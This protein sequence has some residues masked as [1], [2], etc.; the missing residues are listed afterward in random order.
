[1]I[2]YQFIT[3]VFHISFSH[4]RCDA[5]GPSWQPGWSPRSDLQA[6][7][8]RRRRSYDEQHVELH[9]VRWNHDTS[10]HYM[11]YFYIFIFS[12]CDVEVLTRSWP[13]GQK[14]RRLDK[15]GGRRAAP[16]TRPFSVHSLTSSSSRG[17]GRTRGCPWGVC[18]LSQVWSSRLLGQSFRRARTSFLLHQPGGE[19]TAVYYS[20]PLSVMV[21]TIIP[22]RSSTP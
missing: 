16:E 2:I 7:F 8:S 18:D 10:Q 22:F 20:F 6:G 5:R 21:G 11:S 15:G 17:E 3:P 14:G 19:Q 4:P 1:M 13:R 12:S 9:N